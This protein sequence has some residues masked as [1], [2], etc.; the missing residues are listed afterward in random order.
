MQ[1]V[2]LIITNEMVSRMRNVK[3]FYDAMGPH[4]DQWMEKGESTIE[5]ELA[6][7]IATF[8]NPCRILDV[9]CGT[10]RIALP[11]Q[12]QGYDVVGL[13]ISE[14]MIGQAMRKGLKKAYHSDFLDFVYSPA[15]FDGIISLHAGFSYTQDESQIIDMVRKGLGL[16]RTG[17]KILWDTPNEE[18]YGRQRVLEWPTGDTTVKTICYGHNAKH[19][20]ILFEQNGFE[21]RQIWGNYSPLQEYSAGLPRIIIE[22]ERREQ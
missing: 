10:G 22:A 9:G 11:L 1:S 13:D 7:V 21:V 4:Y 3:S 14:G 19:L 8:P 6:L 18:F 15:S 16:L 17:G 2:V 5:D 12:N 20:Q